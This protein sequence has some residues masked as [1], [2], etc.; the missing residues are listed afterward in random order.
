MA[1]EVCLL[2]HLIKAAATKSSK[3]ASCTRANNTLHNKGLKIL[4]QGRRKTCIA[5]K[6][7]EPYKHRRA[8]SGKAPQVAGSLVPKRP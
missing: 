2:P 4:F 3:R 7:Y 1:Y 6:Q 8:Y 5:S